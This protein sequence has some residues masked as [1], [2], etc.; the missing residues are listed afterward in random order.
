MTR[1]ADYTVAGVAAGAVMVGLSWH[2][3]S[4]NPA[5]PAGRVTMVVVV[6]VLAVLPW[7]AR[8]VFGPVA[9]KRAV[10]VVRA[11]GYVAVYCFVLVMAGLSRFAGSRFDHFQA[12]D[13]RNWEADMRSGAVVSAVVI[14]VTIGGYAAAILIAT[15][16]RTRVMPAQLTAG[17]GF[18]AGAAAITYAL[19]PLGNRL[20]L[21]NGWLAAGYTIVLFAVLPAGFWA[22][23]RLGG[24]LGGLYAGG[25]AALVLSVLTIGTMLAFPGHVDLIWANPDPNVAHSTP[26]EVRMSVGDTAIKYQLGLFV[27]PLVGIVIGALGWSAT[28]QRKPAPAV[29]QPV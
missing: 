11:A 10:R 19:M 26:F 14:V 13:Q 2:P 8:P 9:D 16:R 18:G 23:G 25:A 27:L 6:L 5:V 17:A 1:R 24:N 20:H 15:A 29:S 4:A 7:V 21:A 3:G 22:A 28:T 12:F